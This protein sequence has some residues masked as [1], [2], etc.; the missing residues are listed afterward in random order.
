MAEAQV[1]H[2]SRLRD[3]ESGRPRTLENRVSRR[4]GAV[5]ARTRP[6][7]Q[8][9]REEVMTAR[10]IRS[11]VA[12]VCSPWRGAQQPPPVVMPVPT[13]LQNYKPVTAG[14]L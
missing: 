2:R 7:G 10:T 6:Q 14:S 9:I 4:E 1:M 5:D 12:G 11:A 8:K 3:A 13:F